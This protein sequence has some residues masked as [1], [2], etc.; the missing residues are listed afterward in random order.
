MEDASALEALRAA[1]VAAVVDQDAD[2]VRLVTSQRHH[3]HL[4]AAS[5]AVARALAALDQGMPVDL[6]TMDLRAAL[7]ELG[8]ITGAVTNEDV[9]GAIFSRFCIGK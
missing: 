8:C 5:D 9:L 2:T 7:N 1:V 3:A 6:F 4:R